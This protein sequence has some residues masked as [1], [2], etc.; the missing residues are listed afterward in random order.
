MPVWGDL[1]ICF[2]NFVQYHRTV[3]H[4]EFRSRHK[5]QRCVQG[6]RDKYSIDNSNGKIYYQEHLQD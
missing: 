1:K 6:V 3:R 4:F 2:L 5:H